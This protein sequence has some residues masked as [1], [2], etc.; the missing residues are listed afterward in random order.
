VSPAIVHVDVENNDFLCDLTAK[1]QLDL[2][3]VG[4]FIVKK[5]D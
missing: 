5:G 2:R 1:I 4:I 3:K